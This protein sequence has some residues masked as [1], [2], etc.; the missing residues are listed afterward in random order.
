[1]AGDGHFSVAGHQEVARLAYDAIRCLAQGGSGRGADDAGGSV[2]DGGQAA[3]CAVAPGQGGNLSS[4][5][6]ATITFDLV[7]RASVLSP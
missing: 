3:Q 5:G 4:C 6:P 7:G 2:D 1:M